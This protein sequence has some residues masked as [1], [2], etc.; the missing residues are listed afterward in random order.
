MV[1]VTQI[2]SEFVFG[3]QYEDLPD[4][5]IEWTRKYILDYYAAGAAGYRIN[6][7]F[8]QGVE[9]VFLENLAEAKSE[10]LIT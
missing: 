8:N 3:L 9:E 10:L 2:L 1:H 4:D 6:K 7:I 5:V